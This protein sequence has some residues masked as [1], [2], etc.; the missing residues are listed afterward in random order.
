VRLLR[1]AYQHRPLPGVY[2]NEQSVSVFGAGET[3][4]SSRRIART[5]KQSV[6]FT[7]K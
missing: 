5:V 7:R 1:D 4:R 6:G 2:T 3:G